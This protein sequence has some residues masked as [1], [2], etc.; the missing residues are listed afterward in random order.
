MLVGGLSF[1]EQRLDELEQL[2]RAGVRLRLGR[3][4]DDAL[5]LVRKRVEELRPCLL[6]ADDDDLRRVHAADGAV[7]L[8]GDVLQVVGDELLEVPLVP[9]LRNAAL[10][11]AARLVLAP[12]DDLVEAPRP[13]A[14]D[15]TALAADER[16]DRAV[17]AADE[18][19][20]RRE[21]EA[22]ADVHV[23]R[24]R[25]CD[26][27]RPEEVAGHEHGEPAGTFTAELVVEELADPG[28][29]PLQPLSLGV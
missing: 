14:E 7:E 16:D 29:V 11:V 26:R 22:A 3:A 24:D 23:V 8:R 1:L 10:V 15:L 28:E 27:N 17:V 13:Q 6:G 20:E 21:V 9:R 25:P 12:V 19:R 4:D 18:L 2:A 5:D